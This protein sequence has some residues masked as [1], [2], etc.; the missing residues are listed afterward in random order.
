MR[1]VRVNPPRESR[2]I[3]QHCLNSRYA[4]TISL[5]L[6]VRLV[7]TRPASLKL[8]GTRSHPA[9]K[10]LDPRYAAMRGDF[11]KIGSR[12]TKTKTSSSLNA[13]NLVNSRVLFTSASIMTP[14]A[15]RDSPP[16]VDV[17]QQTQSS[18]KRKRSSVS[19][20]PDCKRLSPTN[21]KT[22]AARL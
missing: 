9:V 3:Q 5:Q 12:T 17:E 10:P 1:N 21:L 13:A 6:R 20:I 14:L 22:F 7:T 2:T 16:G 19:G 4:A 18:H 15:N 8:L 11:G